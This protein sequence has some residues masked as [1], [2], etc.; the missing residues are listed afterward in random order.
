MKLNFENI[1]ELENAI[2]S[3][4]STIFDIEGLADSNFI[5]FLLESGIL[6]DE[7]Y[8]YYCNIIE[9]INDNPDSKLT[10]YIKIYY[11]NEN[12]QKSYDKL[13]D[14]MDIEL[15]N[16]ISK[17]SYQIFLRTNY[18]QI[19]SSYKKLLSGNKCQLC[20]SKERLQTH[21]NDYKNRGSEYKNLNDLVVI[22]NKCHSKFHNK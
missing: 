5:W 12:T 20:G 8:N 19:I 14:L 10:N 18:W 2:I 3:N 17:L 6:D 7:D 1:Y 22:C 11:D 4:I 15:E 9:N 16:Y 13:F 21:H